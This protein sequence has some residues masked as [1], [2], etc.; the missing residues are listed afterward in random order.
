MNSNAS[1]TG[2]KFCAFPCRTLFPFV[3]R[4]W[5]WEGTLS[6]IP[7][8]PELLPGTGRELVFHYAAPFSFTADSLGARAAPGVHIVCVRRNIVRLAPTGDTG[9]FAIRFRA[10]AFRHFHPVPAEEMADLDAPLPDASLVFGSAIQEL[11]TEIAGAGGFARRVAL[12][13][14]WLMK[15]LRA[16]STLETA[17]DKAVLHLY[18][19][20]AD[21]SPSLAAAATGLGLRRFQREFKLCMGMTP[22]AFLRLARLQRVIRSIVL[23]E[24]SGVL[25]AAFAQ[26]YYDQ[27]HFIR[28]FKEFTN[29]T[30]AAFFQSG[31][32][33]THFYN[34]SRPENRMLI[35]AD[36][37]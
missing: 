10:G 13:E 21:E 8:L 17:I 23:A 19:A 2:S 1:P 16:R 29:E 26:G 22:K 6:H 14:A 31:R 20:P 7:A 24:R 12:A 28:E 5:A 37:A 11:Q 27:S 35:S 36:T 25:D 18:Y 15:R 34:T 33:R 9:F 3:D 30:P 4:Y 32:G